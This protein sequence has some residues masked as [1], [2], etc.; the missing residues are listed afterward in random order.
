MINTGDGYTLEYR[1]TD[2][3][4]RLYYGE[5]NTYMEYAQTYEL[6]YMISSMNN[7]VA[8]FLL[9]ASSYVCE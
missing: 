3:R 7:S 6:W 9:F 2:N 1:R 5:T 4:M 8:N